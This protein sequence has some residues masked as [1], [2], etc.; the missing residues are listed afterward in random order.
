MCGGGPCLILTP[1]YGKSGCRNGY[2]YVNILPLTF[3]KESKGRNKK[4]TTEANWKQIGCDNGM[5]SLSQLKKCLKMKARQQEGFNKPAKIEL[6][7]VAG[8]ILLLSTE[9]M[10]C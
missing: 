4:R 8:M 10:V 2:P 9:E 3:G 5:V 7:E 6:L 1:L